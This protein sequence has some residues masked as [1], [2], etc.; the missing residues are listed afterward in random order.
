MGGYWPD[1]LTAMAFLAGATTTIGVR[2][3]VM[4]LPY[5]PPI[6]LAK[7]ALRWRRLRDDAECCSAGGAR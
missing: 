6:Q 3:G 4:V 2:S 1:A 5:H 7:A